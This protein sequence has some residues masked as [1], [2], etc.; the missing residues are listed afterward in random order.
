MTVN[1]LILETDDNEKNLFLS[2]AL[3]QYLPV[4]MIIYDQYLHCKILMTFTV[5]KEI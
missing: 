2:P 3:V 1:G 5:I 4:S